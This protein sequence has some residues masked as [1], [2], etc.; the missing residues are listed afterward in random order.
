MDT[1]LRVVV[2]YIFLLAG[3][4]L[5]GKREFGQLSPH[6]FVILLIIPE[7][8][9]SSLNQNDRSLTNAILGTATILTLVFL[10]SI[11]THRFKSFER[12]ISDEEAILVHNGA[13]FEK[14]L[15]KERVTPSEIL[16][17]AH[18]SGVETIEDIKWAILESDGKIA[19]VPK[20]KGGSH[21]P[22]EGTRG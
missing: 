22:E 7:V 11:L 20:Q 16:A 17:E 14:V 19:V 8:V 13:L 15:D 2:I 1:V 21:R 10:T 6:E 18:K 3:M 4:R 12:V 9:S 5:I